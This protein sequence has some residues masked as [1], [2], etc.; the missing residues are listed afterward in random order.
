[1][2][3]KAIEREQ[4]VF[5]SFAENGP[6]AIDLS[7]IESTPPPA[8]DIQCRVE[9]A[10]FVAF[11]LVELIDQEYARGIDLMARTQRILR[12]L[13][14]HLPADLRRSLKETGDPYIAFDF[15]ANLP[16]RVR[17]QAAVD[18]LRWLLNQTDR[19]DHYVVEGDLRWRVEAIHVHL[20]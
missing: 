11:E 2:N 1:M 7:S 6:L 8:P 18:A 19:R 5:R 10:G 13:P 17:E 16:L 20:P 15:V 14:E 12:D 3:V 9:G 4:R